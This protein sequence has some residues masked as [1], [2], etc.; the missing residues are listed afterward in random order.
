MEKKTVGTQSRIKGNRRLVEA[1]GFVSARSLGK[2]HYGTHSPRVFSHDAARREV[3]PRAREDCFFA[4]LHV[5]H[6][7]ASDK[8][9]FGNAQKCIC[10]TR[11]NK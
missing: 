4:T 5:L 2:V 7:D 1:E 8:F 3:K 9:I 11:I 10:V 6:L